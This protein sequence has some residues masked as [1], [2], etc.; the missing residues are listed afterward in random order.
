MQNKGSA[1]EAA[2]TGTCLSDH[3]HLHLLTKLRCQCKMQCR[4]SILPVGWRAAQRLAVHQEVRPNENKILHI[5]EV[6]S[7]IEYTSNYRAA[8]Q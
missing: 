1:Q 7:S 6:I 2:N 3:E 4:T 5:P 8:A